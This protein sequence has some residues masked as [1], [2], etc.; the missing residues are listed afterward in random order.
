M[1]NQKQLDLLSSGK[2]LWGKWRR[3][4]PDVQAVEPDLHGA[5][6]H[7]VDLHGVDLHGADLT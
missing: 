4:Y 6:L 3:A 7:G 1:A 5:D 2:T